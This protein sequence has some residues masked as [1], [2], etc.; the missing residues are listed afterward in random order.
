[1]RRATRSLVA[2][3]V[4][5]AAAA[6]VT[7][8]A[9]HATA[10]DRDV[11]VIIAIDTSAS[12]RPAIDAAKAAAKDFV[13]AMPEGVRIGLATFDD[14]VNV[15][16]APTDDRG[17][18]LWL[19]GTIQLGE[20]TALYD[21][22]VAASREYSPTA[23]HKVLVLLSDGKDVGSTAGLQDAVAAAADV[24]IEAIS[25]TTADT[26]VASLAAL[27]RVTSADDAAGVAAAFARVAALVVEA[28]EAAP[29]STTPPT[30]VPPTTVAPTTVPVTTAAPATTE[31]AAPVAT[32]APPRA[33]RET[34]TSTLIWLGGGAVF[35]GLFLLGLLLAPRSR[36]SKARLGIAKPRTVADMGKRTTSAV[37]EV[38]ARH[39]RRDDLASRLAVAHIGLS[40]GEYVGVVAGIALAAGA[41]G[42]LV[43]GPLLAVVA[44]VCVC[45][46]GRLHVTRSIAKRRAAFSEQLPTVLQLLTTALRSGFGLTQAL[47]SVAEEAEEPARSEF[48]QVLVEARLG[49]DLTE[50]MES[51]ARRMGSED[52]EW[53]VGAIDINRST[54]G[55]LSE[56]LTTIGT[57]VRDRQRMARHV[58]TLTAE[59]RLSAR[60]L[61]VLPFA[62]ALFQ[63]ATNRE[64]FELLTH[65]PG[66]AAVGVAGFLLVLG[67]IWTRRIVTSISL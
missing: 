28:V 52:L 62:M 42:L 63:W 3:A 1:M 39:G 6:A 34:P 16:S 53:V 51:M 11:E 17:T 37:E 40:P 24:S 33:Q 49:R 12:M 13:S 64:S 59:G 26:D 10:K 43:G 23:E 41:A 65:G 58:A 14:A 45:L 61:T 21:M 32:A 50:A 27:G 48:A 60:V 4:G 36:V 54:G 46:G 56:I 8:G 47:E 44:A 18:L 19:I 7:V 30:T 20:D 15:A 5:A 22:V 66:L 67:T 2:L 35:A 55:N 29:A 9:A 38:L 31:A 25:L 57:T